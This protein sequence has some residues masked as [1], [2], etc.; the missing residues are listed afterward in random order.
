MEPKVKIVITIT[1]NHSDSDN[2]KATAEAITNNIKWDDAECE[3][4]EVEA[5]EWSLK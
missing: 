1:L 4:P 5:I 2:A 3:E